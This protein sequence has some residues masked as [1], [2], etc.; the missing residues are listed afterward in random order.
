M[1]VSVLSTSVP[2]EYADYIGFGKV[3]EWPP[4][5]KQLSSWSTICS[6]CVMSICYCTSRYLSRRVYSFCLLARPFVCSFVRSVQLVKYVSKFCITV[7][8]VVN[9]SSTTYQRAF[10]VILEGWH[11]LHDSGYKGPCPGV[12]L[13]VKI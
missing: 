12:G 3:A 2:Y 11:L 5:E 7:S 8:Q 6:L 9:I 4:F 13:K 10:I 1:S